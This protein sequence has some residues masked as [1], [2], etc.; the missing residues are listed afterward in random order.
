MLYTLYMLYMLYMLY[1]LYVLYTLYMLYMLYMLIHI[2]DST[3]QCVR[4]LIL[5]RLFEKIKAYRAMNL[6][7][8]LEY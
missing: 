6:K 8:L 1:V 2:Y 5:F 4:L 7:R 3:L